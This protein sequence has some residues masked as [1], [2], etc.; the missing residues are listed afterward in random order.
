MGCGIGHQP[1]ADQAMPTIGADVVLIP[2]GGDRQVDLLA[3]ILE[4]LGL[5]VLDGPSRVA[6][7]LPEPRRLFLPALGDAAL[8]ERLLLGLGVPLLRC[9]YNA[10]IDELAGHRQIAGR[11]QLPVKKVEQSLNG[12]GLGQLLAEGPDRVRIRYRIP[13]TEAKKADP[14]ETSRK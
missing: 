5:R 14:G 9:G 8:L 13:Q 4:R 2:E 7:L 6:I 12:A 10:R 1:F 3:A 11:P